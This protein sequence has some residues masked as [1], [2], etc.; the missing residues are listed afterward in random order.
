PALLELPA[1]R[2]RPAV[3]S[4]RGAH[5]AMELGEGLL[6]RLEA[7]GRREGAT[8]YM[9]LLS[10]FQV[11]L[12][13]YAGTDDV[14][15][16]SPIAGRTRAETEPL[17][18]FFVNTLVL[19]T[20]LGGDPT[21]REVVARVRTA[22]LAAYEHQDVPFERLVAELAPERSLSHAPLFQVAF[23]LWNTGDAVEPLPGLAVREM[24]PG[25]DTAK[26]D[27]SLGLARDARGM[28]GELGYSTDLFDR[29]TIARMLGHLARVLE[30]VAADA[31]QPLSRLVLLDD[32]ERAVVVDE[33]NRTDAAYPADR[34]VH[35]LFQA[36]AARTPDAAAVTAAGRV[37]SYAELNAQANRI[38]RHLVRL[39]VGP[40]TR[41]GLCLERGVEMVAALLGVLK[42][43]G[44]YVPLD[45]DYPAERLAFMLAD[46]GAAV[47]VTEAG[48]RDR[49]PAPAGMQVVTLE[50][51]RAALAAEGTADL[52][53]GAQPGN[54]AYVIYT[55]GSTGRP[56]AVGVPHGA[57]ANHMAWMQDAYPLAADDRVLQKTP[58]TFDASV[59]E[60]YAPLLAGA[61]LVMAGPEAHRDPAELLR[62]LA[63]ERITILQGV[64][65]YLGAVLDAGGTEH[66]R[67]LRRLFSGGEAL[68]AELAERAA[69]AFGAQVVNLYGPTE[70]CID[71]TSHVFVA[72]AAGGQVPIGRPVANTRAYV[73]DAGLAPVPAGIPGE[74]YI[75]GA[76]VTR[77][78]LGRPGLTAERFVPDPFAS[79]AGARLYRTGDRV[80]WLADGTLAYLGRLDEQVKVRGF[81]IETGEIEAVLRRAGAAECAVVA[82]D[83]EGGTRLVAYVTG[84]VEADALRA[85]L[86]RSLPEYMVPAAFVAMDVLPLTPNGKLDRKALPAP[87]FGAA[88]AYVAPRTVTEEVLAGIISELLRV[89][90]V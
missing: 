38:A 22:T 60:F 32:A 62:N 55:S 53:G 48:L 17:I 29:A 39:G 69:R 67:S 57:L 61:T 24:E 73:L 52:D 20:E 9:V 90:R 64:P 50:D 58:L 23:A 15:V 76:Q 68:P 28:R 3:Q 63:D 6:E 82:R 80:R 37:L 70:T 77:G 66:V 74:L 79:V 10:A 4:Y 12:G 89:D 87:E 27:L 30:Q 40:E 45:P 75:G 25:L 8:L 33:W 26:F 49:L 21:F 65:A 56:K 18:G 7:L 13:K 16:G 5:E 84:N 59:W 34:C 72:G 85:A 86:R 71:A 81:R 51:A 88:D 47:L 44:A 54:L 42:A 43:G 78:Y 41:V 2:P 36:Q 46:S 35:A 19:R 31:D 83:G 11:L 1:D 14:V